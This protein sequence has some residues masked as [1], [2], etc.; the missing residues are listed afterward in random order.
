MTI[1]IIHFIQALKMKEEIEVSVWSSAYRPALRALRI[2]VW[3]LDIRITVAFAVLCLRAWR[4]VSCRGVIPRYCPRVFG[5]VGWKSG[6]LEH[7]GFRLILI[8]IPNLLSKVGPWWVGRYDNCL[9]ICTVSVSV[10]L[11]AVLS[12]LE[13]CVFNQPIK[14]WIWIRILNMSNSQQINF[15]LGMKTDLVLGNKWYDFQLD[16]FTIGPMVVK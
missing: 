14:S 16:P 12:V 4:F 6:I 8:L 11:D 13:N 5:H 3:L 15:K 9:N 7:V 10:F 2:K 1:I